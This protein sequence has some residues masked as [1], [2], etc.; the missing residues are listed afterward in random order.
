[1]ERETKTKIIKSQKRG[2][3]C[4]ILKNYGDSTRDLWTFY[5][6]I[7]IQKGIKSQQVDNIETTKE[8]PLFQ[9]IIRYD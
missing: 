2:Y 4:K 3:F 1:M 5:N 8:R 9:V 7:I 6:S